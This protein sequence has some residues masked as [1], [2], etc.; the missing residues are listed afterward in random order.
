MLD[1]LRIAF[2]ID[3]MIAGLLNLEGLDMEDS[4]THGGLNGGYVFADRVLRKED[5]SFRYRPVCFLSERQLTRDLE[6]DVQYLRNRSDTD[7]RPH[8]SIEYIRKRSSNELGRF[9]KFLARL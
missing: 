5:S 6:E 4:D 1:N 8:G 9:K 7:G 3:V 2:I